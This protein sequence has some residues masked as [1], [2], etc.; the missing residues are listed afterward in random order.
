MPHSILKADLNHLVMG[1]NK[2]YKIKTFLNDNIRPSKDNLIGELRARNYKI[3][4][5]KNGWELRPIK[6]PKRF[7]VI[8][9]G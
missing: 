8:K 7:K 5:G 3:A 4:K 2:L 6:D 1:Y 9:L